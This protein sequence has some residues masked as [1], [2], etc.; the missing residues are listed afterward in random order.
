[1]KI[2]LMWNLFHIR[3]SSFHRKANT[4]HFFP[5]HT[6]CSIQNVQHETNASNRTYI[7]TATTTTT[8]KTKNE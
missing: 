4:K 5:L 7:T 2:G 8:T 6:L 1:M 3:F